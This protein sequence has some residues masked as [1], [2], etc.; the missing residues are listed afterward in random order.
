[1]PVS[2]E[3]LLKHR[4]CS[5][6]LIH[7]DKV[8]IDVCNILRWWS[9]CC[10]R[11]QGKDVCNILRWWSKCCGRGQGKDVCNILRLWSKCCGRGQGNWCCG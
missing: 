11:G 7:F 4:N 1:M 3:L 6:P 5:C 8:K 9:K 2:L 10:G